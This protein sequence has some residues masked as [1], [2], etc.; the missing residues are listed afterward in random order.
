[1]DTCRVEGAVSIEARR[2]LAAQHDP[3]ALPS[4]WG[5]YRRVLVGAPPQ[6]AIQV[7]ISS[8]STTGVGSCI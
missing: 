8:V 3:V 5:Y 7:Y 6:S 4:K 1:M 2:R